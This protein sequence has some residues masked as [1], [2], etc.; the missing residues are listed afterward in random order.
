MFVDC[1]SFCVKGLIL[2]RCNKRLI[3]CSV[4]IRGAQQGLEAVSFF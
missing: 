2:N 3:W 4:K 1:A